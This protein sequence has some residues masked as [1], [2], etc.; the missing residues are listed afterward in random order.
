M[1]IFEV[2]WDEGLAYNNQIARETRILMTSF[3]AML[4][5]KH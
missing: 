1:P 3:V 4:G 2:V 5:N